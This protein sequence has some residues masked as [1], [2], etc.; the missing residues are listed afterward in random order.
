VEVLIN[1]ELDS[2]RHDGE[3]SADTEILDCCEFL[4][5]VTGAPVSLATA[6]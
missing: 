5:F 1:Q 2:V 4:S 3:P 6:T